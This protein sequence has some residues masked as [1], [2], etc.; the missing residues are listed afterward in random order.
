MNIKRCEEHLPWQEAADT[1]TLVG[2]N[3]GSGWE[4]F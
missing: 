2:F 3:P 4:L 1:S